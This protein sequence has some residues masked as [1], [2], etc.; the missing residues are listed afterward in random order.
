MVAP[1]TLQ[2][3]LHSSPCCLLLVVQGALPTSL[4]CETTLFVS[5]VRVGPMRASLIL[6]PAP[7]REDRA[8]VGAALQG[9]TS[10]RSSSTTSQAW[11]CADVV[12]TRRVRFVGGKVCDANA[13]HRG[14]STIHLSPEWEISQPLHNFT[15]GCAAT[16]HVKKITCPREHKSR[17]R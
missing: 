16:V 1:L 11:A 2:E 9:S 7:L 13:E 15:G 14:C 6:S 5:T 4:I 17:R 10:P 12:S 8:G 3:S